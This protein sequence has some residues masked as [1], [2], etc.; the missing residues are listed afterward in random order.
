MTTIILCFSR[1]EKDS[2]VPILSENTVNIYE[3]F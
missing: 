3:K 1:L 2:K